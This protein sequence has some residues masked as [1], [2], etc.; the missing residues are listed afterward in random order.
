MPI[1]IEHSIDFV[2]AANSVCMCIPNR[3]KCL[4]KLVKLGWIIDT[5]S[6]SVDTNAGIN[7]E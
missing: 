6:K 7:A 3:Y 5:F 1:F 2:F 4:C